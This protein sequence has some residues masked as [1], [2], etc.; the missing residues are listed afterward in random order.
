[1]N[2]MAKIFV[3]AFVSYLCVAPL[4]FS[5]TKAEGDNKDPK[6]TSER[7]NDN[8]EQKGSEQQRDSS[9][10]ASVFFP[11]PKFEFDHMVDGE[12]LLHDFVIMNK[13][14]ELLKVD[15]VKTTC[16]CTTVSYSKEIPPGKEGKISMKVNTRGYGGRK[17]TKTIAVITND[18]VTPQSL[19][20]VSGNIE[21]FV[22]I[23]PSVL[24]LNGKIGEEFKSV[25]KIIPEGKYPFSIIKISAQ[26]GENIKYGLKEE[27]SDSGGKEYSVTVENVKKDS[28]SYYDVLILET[29]SKI[30]PE[31]KIN[32]MA[33]VIDPNG[34]VK[35][36]LT[37][38][39]GNISAPGNKASNGSSETNS[40]AN[41][42]SFLEAIRKAEG[43]K[44]AGADGNAATAQSH[45]KIQDPKRAEELKKKF[46]AL[47]KQA[48]E[49][50]K[51]Q[52]QKKGEGQPKTE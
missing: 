32:L 29:D 31:I 16:G 5:A 51:N 41:G 45:A 52:E 50:Q 40:N 46:E 20:T 43:E 13:G 30:Q 39:G 17:L 42:N 22:T 14:G 36:T 27:K 34:P 21:K 28:G 11:S 6:V 19:L 2:R 3:Y 18:S 9:N 37:G 26:S 38:S 7:K 8:A 33:R 49:K 23:T 1:M 35:E 12:E 10:R 15:R 44:P 48:Q 4:C 25:V 47:I 24:R